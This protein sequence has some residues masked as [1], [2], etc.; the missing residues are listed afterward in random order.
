MSAPS[1]AV[2]FAELKCSVCGEKIGKEHRKVL[3]VI[4]YFRTGVWLLRESCQH[5]EPGYIP[6]DAV[7]LAS[8]ECAAQWLRKVGQ[9][10]T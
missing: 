7:I 6:A 3:M 9:E 5:N 10:K 2:P 1:T 4:P 8:A